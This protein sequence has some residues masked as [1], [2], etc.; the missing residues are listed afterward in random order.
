MGIILSLLLILFSCL[1]IWRACDGFEAASKY[2]GRNLSDGVRGGTIN[3]ISSSLPEFLTTLIALFSINSGDVDGNEMAF[4][5]GIGTTAGSALFNGMVI[6]AAC[7]LAV[8]GTVVM[9]R[10]ITRVNVSTRVLVRDGVALIF[11]EMVLVLFLNGTVLYW[12]HGL[13]LLLLYLAYLGTMLWTMRRN[14]QPAGSEALSES[15]LG[16]SLDRSSLWGRLL[17]WMSLGP[18]LDFQALFVGS[19]AA[20]KIDQ[21]RWNCWPLLTASLAAIGGSCWLLVLGCEWL[22]SGEEHRFVFLGREL[23]PGLGMPILFV[24]VVFASMAT[25]VPDAV[26]SIRDARQG[27][28]D[29]AVA[30]ALGSNIFDICFALGF[31]LFLYGLFCKPVEM[32]TEVAAQ[33][34]ELRFI[35]LCLTI[36]AFAIYLWG[37]RIS[38][39]DGTTDVPLGRGKACLLLAVYSAFVFY[40]LAQG[41][42]QNWAIGLSLWLRESVL[43]HL[44]IFESH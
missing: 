33:S 29:D 20:A 18:A 25:S 34:A 1:L 35:L 23:P 7:I 6:P 27:E 28:Y 36:V 42:E 24:A 31:P 39:P 4:S 43:E 12:W 5:V 8:V 14:S 30:N 11:C 44:H 37:K 19:D 17:Y 9:G 15:V 16:S 32:G 13:V 10:R 2:L 22:G 26:M 21:Q 38:R 41:L 3:A 40:V